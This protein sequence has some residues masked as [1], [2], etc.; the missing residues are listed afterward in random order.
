M[1]RQQAKVIGDHIA[2]GE[3][4]R[5]I[6]EGQ[7]GVEIRLPLAEV[8]EKVREMWAEQ[9]EESHASSQASSRL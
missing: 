8:E 6:Q 1:N 2:P 4:Q 3:T 7:W 5:A 9:F